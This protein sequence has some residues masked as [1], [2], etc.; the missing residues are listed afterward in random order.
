M[1]VKICGIT[2]VEDAQVVAWAGAAA[3]GLNF[4]GGPRQL[5]LEHA[6]EILE[7]V[8]P[9]LT[10]VALVR[11]EGDTLADDL[12]ELLGQYWVSHLQVYGAVR[13]QGLVSLAGNGFKTLPVLAMRDE[14]SLAL[15]RP[16]VDLPA[17]SRPAAIV[18]DAYD[19]HRAGGTGQAFQWDLVTQAQRAGRLDGWPPIIIAGGLHPGNVA[20]TVRLMQ[21]YGVDVS[22]GVEVEGS[23]GRKDPTRVL[24]FT[25]NAYAAAQ[26]EV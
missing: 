5:T 3:I 13:P 9:L 2:S 12:L 21:P 26:P 20:E 18:L 14:G 1:R 19:P 24:D 23:S 17:G 10:P 8:P 4:V 6:A 7:H 11:L 25:R 16:W 22:S 15:A